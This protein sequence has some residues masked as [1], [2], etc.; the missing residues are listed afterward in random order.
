MSTPNDKKFIELCK[1]IN[2]MSIG[3]I[4]EDIWNAEKRA[5]KA[6]ADNEKL[7]DIHR[8]YNYELNR[9]NE[10]EARVKD[11]E[12][13]LNHDA[14]VMNQAGE[15]MIKLSNRMNELEKMVAQYKIKYG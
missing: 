7:K 4:A 2:T 10:L 1:Q 9:G 15:H 5:D 13:K 14:I 3:E 11:L 6:E 8:H 12:A